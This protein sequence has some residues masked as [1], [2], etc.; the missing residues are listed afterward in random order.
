M[1]NRY[2][3]YLIQKGRQQKRLQRKHLC[4]GICDF[5]I[6]KK[7]ETGKFQ[8]DESIVFRLLNR[9]EI[10]GAEE[11]SELFHMTE[12]AYSLFF[13]YSFPELSGYLSEHPQIKDSVFAMDYE[14]LWN[15]LHQGKPLP[16]EME[17]F[18]DKRQLSAQFLL[19]N[20]PEAAAQEY[21]AAL[22]HYFSA[23]NAYRAHHYE[24]AEKHF[25][26]TYSVASLE[27]SIVLMLRAKTALGKTYA[28]LL[29]AEKM[30]ASY[31]VAKRI[32][33][34]LKD[35]KTAG[36]ISYHEASV[37]IE[38]GYYAEAYRYFRNL[39]NPSVTE[40]YKMA[41]LAEKMNRKEDWKEA[42]ERLENTAHL[43]PTQKLLT[44]CLR[45]R[46][47]DPDYLKDREYSKTMEE[48]YERLRKHYPREYLLSFL[49]DYLDLLDHTNRK[50]EADLLRSHYSMR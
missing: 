30:K 37:Q 17:S 28:R 6:L 5:S 45:F 29:D 18:M 50:K 27:G 25:A 26:E 23:Q 10:P 44:A 3:G 34:A 48:C 31:D 16:E 43:S 42:L 36:W 33:G 12:Y 15:V 49:P 7:V 46:Y 47:D 40:I 9:L 35:E 2:L 21:P 22:Y 24:K 13:I 11:D 32:A 4:E 41:V 1:N 20:N 14:L 39:N 38:L 19:K 8:G